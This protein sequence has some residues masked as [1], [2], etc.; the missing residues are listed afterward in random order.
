MWAAVLVALAVV[1][2]AVARLALAIDAAEQALRLVS[3][4][5]AGH[6]GAGGW[7]HVRSWDRAAMAD[8]V[9]ELGQEQ[10]DRLAD[11]LSRATGDS[12]LEVGYWSPETQD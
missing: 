5:A 12:I 11:G 1:G 9:V 2:G 6:A 8:L 4:A 3:E 7:G 10:S